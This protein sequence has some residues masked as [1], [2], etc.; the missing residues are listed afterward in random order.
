MDAQRKSLRVGTWAILL[1]IAVRL[2]STGAPER[3]WEWLRQ[4]ETAAILMYL[5]TGKVFRP[6]PEEL[7]QTVPPTE[8]PEITEPAPAL[9]RFS[10]EDAALVTVRDTSGNTADIGAL[11]ELP[12]NWDLTADTPAV[13]I[14]HTHATESYTQ[15]ADD[16][17]SE[18]SDFRTLDTAHN[19]VSIG[20]HLEN[21]LTQA[22]IGVIR[23]ETLH[24]YPSYDGG[25]DSS[26]ETI[27]D[28]LSSHSSIQLVLD[29][30]RDAAVDANGRQ[31]ATAATVN[32]QESAQILFLIGTGHP[33]WRE[34]MALAAKLTVL[35]EK[36]YPGIT[37]GILTRTYDY[38]QDLSAGA[39]LVEVGA[40]GDTR[41]K[42]L[43][44]VEAL[45]EAIV[46]LAKGTG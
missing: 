9:P 42:A 13:L 37:R 26:R 5:E 36:S 28:A 11:L 15:T 45:S 40:A 22:G 31:F 10:P 7:P 30:H 41:Q 34:N 14:Y 6:P 32:G 43:M 3:F 23:S 39:L 25:Y 19:M 44:A 2:V 46:A 24:D 20:S 17:Y 27:T 8:P 16:L 4:P 33:N 12:L 35:L 1:A 29:L 21:L 18:S 38:N